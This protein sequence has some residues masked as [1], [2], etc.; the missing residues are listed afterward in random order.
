[1]WMPPTITHGCSMSPHNEIFYDDS[2][3][4]ECIA[5]IDLQTFVPSTSVLR[6]IQFQQCLE[7]FNSSSVLF[8]RSGC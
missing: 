1:M 2:K 4:V 8:I 7:R 5:V 3:V 6:T